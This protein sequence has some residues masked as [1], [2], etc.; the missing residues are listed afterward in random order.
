MNGCLRR[1]VDLPI[2]PDGVSDMR[3]ID[4][5]QHL[6]LTKWELLAAMQA[7]SIYVL[8]RIGEGETDHNNFDV[9]LVKAVTVGSSHPC[10]PS[11]LASILTIRGR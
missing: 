6:K 11:P 3:L 5:F 7:L 10:P 4:I 8:I 9:L 2:A 1:Y